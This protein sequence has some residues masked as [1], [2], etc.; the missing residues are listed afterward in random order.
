MFD[1]RT[2]DDDP[3]GCPIRPSARTIRSRCSTSVTATASTTRSTPRRPGRDLLDDLVAGLV[4]VDQSNP[5]LVEMWGASLIGGLRTGLQPP[6]S[7]DATT[8]R[9]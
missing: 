6:V 5:L 2:F 8:R 4:N 7:L 1:R 9:A 3:F